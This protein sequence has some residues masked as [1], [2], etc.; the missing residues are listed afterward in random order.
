MHVHVRR[1][2]KELSVHPAEQ[3]WSELVR[4]GGF[5]WL[6]SHDALKPHS[7][8]RPSNGAAGGIVTFSL[9]QSRIVRSLL[10]DTLDQF[11]TCRFYRRF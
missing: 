5:D 7:S 8:Q 1:G 9:Q 3:A 11:T 2:I 4:H 6:A 10:Y